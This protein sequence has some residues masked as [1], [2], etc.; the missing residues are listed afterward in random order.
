MCGR[1]TLFEPDK[2]LAKEFGV[3]DLPRR[4]PNPSPGVFGSLDNECPGSIVRC[5]WNPH[6]PF[7]N[8]SNSSMGATGREAV[9]L[10]LADGVMPNSMSIFVIC[11]NALFAMDR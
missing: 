1:F 3:S 10:A 4:S 6:L 9:T 11:S 8:F 2:V 5:R 7:I